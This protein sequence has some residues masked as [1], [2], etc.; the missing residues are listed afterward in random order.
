[1]RYEPSLAMR[2]DS[3]ARDVTRALIDKSNGHAGEAPAVHN[4]INLN[5][6]VRRDL[7]WQKGF[8]YSGRYATELETPATRKLRCSCPA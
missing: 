4:F 8:P 6:F 1:M 5:P 3:Q 7:R 2:P